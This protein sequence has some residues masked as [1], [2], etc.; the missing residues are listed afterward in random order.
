MIANVSTPSARIR[1]MRNDDSICGVFQV[2]SPSQVWV[3][4][5]SLWSRVLTTIVLPSTVFLLI[6]RVHAASSGILSAMCLSVV[7]RSDGCVIRCLTVL[8][9]A[10][11]ESG[12]PCHDCERVQPIRINV[13]S[14]TTNFFFSCV[15]K[16][17]ALEREGV[18]HRVGFA[19]VSSLC[20][21]RSNG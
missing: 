20:D 18:C 13:G 14:Q 17:P 15:V 16:I 21:R 4:P 2:I 12:R 9:R 7:F 3:P 11:H 19:P 5:T 10:S 6:S 8:H 1:R